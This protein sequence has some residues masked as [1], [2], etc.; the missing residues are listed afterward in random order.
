[1]QSTAYL[2]MNLLFP[3]SKYK[4]TNIC[5]YICI[6]YIFVLSFIVCAP[7]IFLYYFFGDHVGF[8]ITPYKLFD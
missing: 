8:H 1:M 4:Q 6:L 3:C 5:I 7:Y 2:G